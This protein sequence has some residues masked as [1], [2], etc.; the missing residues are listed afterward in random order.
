MSWKYQWQKRVQPHNQQVAQ[1]AKQ[2]GINELVATLLL[3]RGIKTSDQAQSF[4][5]PQLQNLH[6]PYLLHDMDKAVER[7]TQALFS[8]E[9]ILI[10]G[11]YDADGM[12]SAA[13]LKLALTNLGGQATVFIPNRFQDGYGPNLERY[14]QFVQEG[15]QLIVTVDNG[16]TGLKEIEYAQ[17]HQVDVIV[18]DHHNLPSRLPPAVA[19]VHPRFTQ[20]SYPCPNLSGAGVAFKLASALLEEPPVELL[21][22][23]AIGTIADMV[24]LTDENRIL[25]TWGLKQMQQHLRVGLQKLCAHAHVQ[26]KT[27]TEDDISFQIA[28]R[29]NSLGRLDQASKGV[30]LLTTT[31]TAQAQKLAQE[32]EGLNQKRKTLTQEVYQAALKQAQKQIQSQNKIL[33]LAGNNW[34]QG[35]LGIVAGKIVEQTRHPTVVLS[36]QADGRAVGSARSPDNFNLYQALAALRSLYQNFGGHAQACGL[37]LAAKDISQWQQ[38]LNALPQVQEFNFEQKL[39][40]YYDLELTPSTINLVLW[41]QLQQLA[42]FGQGNNLPIIKVVDFDTYTDQYLGSK[43]QLH[44]KLRLKQQQ[45]FLEV[46]AFNW[47]AQLEQVQKFDLQAVYGSL[48]KNNW[49]QQS[50]LQLNLEDVDFK[51]IIVHQ[52]QHQ[53]IDLRAHRSLENQIQQAENLVFFQEQHLQT[54]Q[55]QYS[56]AHCLLATQL[57]PNLTQM[58]LIDRPTNL[59]AFEQFIVNNK[60]L[61]SLELIFHT[62]Y[63][64]YYQLNLSAATWHQSL[65]YFH[66]HQNLTVSD[67]PVVAQYLGLA[68]LEIKFILKVFSE[69]K[70]VKIENGLLIHPNKIPQRQLKESPTY[71]QINDLIAVQNQLIDSKTG[72]VINYIKKILQ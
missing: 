38:Q 3:Q 4:L 27:L 31:D 9:K 1:L 21:D 28:P 22:L 67:L 14:Q 26:A 6:D 11:D 55:K 51:A 58:S 35:I 49:R 10:Y 17:A 60:Q 12:T 48:L 30:E 47:G 20:S 54:V 61:T 42:P 29:L 65:K 15:Y 37:T 46:V 71:C 2:A 43:N 25:V 66:N 23:A 70:F 24:K 19:L 53:L 44:L 40:R 32:I 63:P 39:T 56:Q 52:N 59:K 68:P 57:A 64:L 33:V 45:Q 5:H 69:L 62:R 16:I 41:Q 7:L 34:H 50:H 8:D 13:I 36:I 72:E 18:T